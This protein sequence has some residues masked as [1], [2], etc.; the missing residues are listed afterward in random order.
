[1]NND[2]A[3]FMATNKKSS[4]SNESCETCTDFKDWM[5]QNKAKKI[6]GKD[7]SNSGGEN[8]H[9]DPKINTREQLTNADD[10]SISEA[11]YLK[12]CPLRRDQFGRYAWSYLHTMAAY[13]PEKPTVEQ[14][15]SMSQFIST[16]AE[17]FPCK[18][19]ADD[20]KDE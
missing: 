4:K 12:E 16:F 3:K 1:M 20:F 11:A 2:F 5:N 17:F 18:E 8:F 13:Y 7:N 15:T 10:N 9:S 6:D 19:C 14:Q